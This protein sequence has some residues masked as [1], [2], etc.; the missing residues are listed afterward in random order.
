MFNW[1]RSWIANARKRRDEARKPASSLT[2]PPTREAVQRALE[3]AR[4]TRD[5]DAVDYTDL[6]PGGVANPLHPL[7]PVTDPYGLRSMPRVTDCGPVLHDAP[8]GPET[9]HAAPAAEIAS[10]PHAAD[11]SIS[12]SP[13]PSVAD[14][15]SESSYSSSSGSDHSSS[16][17]FGSSSGGGSFD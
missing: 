13:P 16:S 17:D 6:Y 3:S 15:S 11:H 4:R 10:T 5:N 9:R 8:A 14:C 2:M 7:N 1:F 12:Y